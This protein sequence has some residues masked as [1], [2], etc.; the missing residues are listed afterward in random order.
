MIE[1]A[2]QISRLLRKINLFAV[3]LLLLELCASPAIAQMSIGSTTGVLPQ[4]A[5]C[6][7][8]LIRPSPM[9]ASPNQQA[10]GMR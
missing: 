3:A 1:E 4:V 10:C 7:P 6:R 8:I 5:A 2:S 9:L